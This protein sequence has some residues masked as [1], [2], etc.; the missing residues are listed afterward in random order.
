MLKH[1]HEDE[2]ISESACRIG[3]VVSYLAKKNGVSEDDTASACVG[4]AAYHA[5]IRF[6]RDRMQTEAGEKAFSESMERVVIP[7]IEILNMEQRKL[8]AG[9]N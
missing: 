2:A 3:E 9:R 7:I 5:V 6:F 8:S 4:A 1:P